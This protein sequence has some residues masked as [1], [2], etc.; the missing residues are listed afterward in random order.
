MCEAV[1][2]RVWKFRQGL[3]LIM[4]RFSDRAGIS[5]G[6]LSKIEHV[7]TAPTLVHLA[8]ADGCRSRP[9]PRTRLGARHRHCPLGG[10][11]TEILHE[12]SRPSRQYLD[13]GSLR[14]SNRIVE[15]R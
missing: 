11:G 8:N 3:G 4:A 6:P 5:I 9:V 14:E 13:L 7:W 2:K 10:E 15:S 1:G 12:G